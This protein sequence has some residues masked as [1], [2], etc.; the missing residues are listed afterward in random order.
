MY[1]SDTKSW[2]ATGGFNPASVSVSDRLYAGY[3]PELADIY[4]AFTA[5]CPDVIVI[6]EVSLADFAVLFDH[7]NS[8]KAS[9]GLS[10]TIK[11]SKMTVLARSGETLFSK[12]T[13]NSSGA[14][15]KKACTAILQHTG[16]HGAGGSKK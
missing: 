16:A 15:V 2:A 13:Y 5:D 10:V 1:V 12:S 7:P 14:A 4:Q 9:A 3:D 6:Q 11:P 8:D